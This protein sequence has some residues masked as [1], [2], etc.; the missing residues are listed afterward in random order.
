MSAVSESTGEENPVSESVQAITAFHRRNCV[1]SAMG[2]TQFCQ[3]KFN[4]RN[5]GISKQLVLESTFTAGSNICF[6][7]IDGDFSVG[8][9]IF[10]K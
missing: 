7:V 3:I 2:R 4:V 9:Y 8:C 6:A 5:A 1:K 10:L